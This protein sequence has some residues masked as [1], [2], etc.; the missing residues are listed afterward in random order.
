MEPLAQTGKM[1]HL[2]SHDLRNHLAAVYS[3]VQFMNESM[4][5]PA[6][7]KKLEEEV[8]RAI[9]D[10]TDMLDSLLLFAQTGQALHPRREML[11]LLVEH[12]VSLVRIHP[13]ARNVDLT[14]EN[15]PYIE[16]WVDAKKFCRAIYNL[17]LNACQAAKRGLPPGKVEIAL[18]EEEGL[19]RIRIVDSGPGV[20][21][22]VRKTIYE[23]FVSCETKNGIGLGL[24]IAE[25][26]ARE[27]G[28][29][30]GIEESRPGR[31]VFVLHLLKQA[32][33]APEA[34]DAATRAHGDALEREAVCISTFAKRL[35]HA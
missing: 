26:T 35:G 15:M 25:R 11:N 8:C 16:G 30:V 21:A 12:A 17:L 10:M 13:D 3:N 9:H 2:I 31:T 19:V 32:L 24:T 34:V 7:R 14:V 23:P 29:F 1:A 22:S 4:T 33:K 18:T 20:P 5:H 28:G 6:E 27:H